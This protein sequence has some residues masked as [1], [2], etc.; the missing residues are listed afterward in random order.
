MAFRVLDLLAQLPPAREA[1]AA[2]LPA[3]TAACL[4]MGH[5]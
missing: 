1:L 5:Y 4:A 2:Q 3:L